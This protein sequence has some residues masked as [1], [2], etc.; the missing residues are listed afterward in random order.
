MSQM[1]LS[2]ENIILYSRVVFNSY[3]PSGYFMGM[4]H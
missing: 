2:A 3:T 1:Y 4:G